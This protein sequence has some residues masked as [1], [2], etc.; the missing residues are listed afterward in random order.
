MQT[1]DIIL[2]I[3]L[4]FGAYKGYKRGFSMT[5]FKFIALILGLVLGFKLVHIGAQFLA[6]FIGDANGFLPLLS[7]FIIFIGVII[8]VNFIGKIVQ[9]SLQILFLGGIDS[10]AG[11]VLNLIRWGFLLGTGLWLMERSGIG[12]SSEQVDKSIIYP[13]LIKTAPIII[14]FFSNLMPFA[15]DMVDYIKE[16]KN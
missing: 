7:F 4:L 10:I 16:L 3:P 5:I 11:A 8:F 2:L 15:T 1:I 9:K 12:L 13:V 14:D 6:P